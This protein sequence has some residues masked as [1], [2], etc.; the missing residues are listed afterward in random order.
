MPETEL[1]IGEAAPLASSSVVAPPGP[2]REFWL[3][4]SQS[5]G[6]IAGLV[7]IVM[8]LLLAALAGAISP[9]PPNEQYRQFTLVPPVWDATGNRDFILGSA[10]LGRDMLS[11][12]IHG[13]RLSLLIGFISVALSLTLGVLLGLIAGYVRG[14]TETII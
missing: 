2:L 5:R 7:L 3:A 10:P 13:T 9:H 11:R 6:A 14:I 1:T 8:L 4:Y 12:L